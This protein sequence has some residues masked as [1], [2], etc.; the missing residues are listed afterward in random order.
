M[1]DPSKTVV[2]SDTSCLIVLYKIGHLELLN[3]LYDKVV[4]TPE[5]QA[6]FMLPMPPWILVEA[7]AD[8]ARQALF[9]KVLDP[10]EASAMALASSIPGAKLILDDGKA[11]RIAHS[12]GFDYTG[13]LG[14]IVR[15]KKEGLIGAAKPLFE[16][17]LA[18]DFRISEAVLRELERQ[19]DE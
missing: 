14:V 13:T 3:Q 11:R 16:A 18:I 15:A 2:I 10:G 5:I 19:V 9:N 12:F 6:E 7:V 1:P 8:R 17:L 4:V